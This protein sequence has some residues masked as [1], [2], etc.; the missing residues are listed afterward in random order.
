MKKQF[1]IKP[2][3]RRVIALLILVIFILGFVVVN[4]PV[5]SRAGIIYIVLALVC[6]VFYL[7]AKKF[8]Q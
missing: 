3:Y 6:L 4:S 2:E 8:G 1:K 7:E 5:W